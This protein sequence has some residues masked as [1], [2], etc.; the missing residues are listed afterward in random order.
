MGYY[1]PV[2]LK[3]AVDVIPLSLQEMKDAALQASTNLLTEFPYERSKKHDDI[4]AITIQKGVNVKDTDQ[5]LSYS[6]A[7]SI[8]SILHPKGVIQIGSQILLNDMLRN[9]V[10]QNDVPLYDALGRIYGDA[11]RTKQMSLYTYLTHQDEQSWFVAGINDALILFH[12][13]FK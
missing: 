12:E 11:V 4:I 6:Y 10:L 8:C 9:L 3:N 7:V 13:T 1:Q 2:Q 5:M